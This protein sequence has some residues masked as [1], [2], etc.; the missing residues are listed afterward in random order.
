MLNSHDPSFMPRKKP[1]PF[2]VTWYPVLTIG[3]SSR[4]AGSRYFSNM[5][6]GSST[7]L[8]ASM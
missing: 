2:A 6:S 4:Y 1:V 8:S 7:W 3:M 5:S